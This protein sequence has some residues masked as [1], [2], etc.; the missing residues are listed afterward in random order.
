[1]SAHIYTPHSF[2]S[3]VDIKTKLVKV[4]IKTSRTILLL[5]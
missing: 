5:L 1:M 2:I 3:D 4:S